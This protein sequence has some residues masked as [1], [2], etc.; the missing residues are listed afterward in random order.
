MSSL[1]ASAI[2]LEDYMS[3]KYSNTHTHENQILQTTGSFVLVVDTS[4]F[5]LVKKRSG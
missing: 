3:Y 2:H 5:D 1:D 4:S